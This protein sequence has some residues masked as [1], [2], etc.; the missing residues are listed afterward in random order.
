[1][2]D[3]EGTSLYLLRSGSAPVRLSRSGT[4]LDGY[5]WSPDGRYLAFGE[6]TSGATAAAGGLTGA[7]AIGDVHL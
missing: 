2:P 1:M 3:A 7:G 6:V 5:V 4:F